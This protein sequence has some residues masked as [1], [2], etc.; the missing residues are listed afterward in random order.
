MEDGDLPRVGVGLVGPA[1]GAYTQVKNDGTFELPPA[2]GAG[3]FR[4]SVDGLPEESYVKSVHF[5]GRDVTRAPLDNTAGAGGAL[6]IV[7]STKA[8]SLGGTAPKGTTVRTWP[9]I[10]DLG[11]YDGGVKS[12]PT[13]QEGGFKFTSLAPGEYYV[14]AWKELESGLADSPEFLARF[15]GDASLVKLEESGRATVEV[16]VIPPERIAAEIAR[17]P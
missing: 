7:L 3:M 1:D 5:V 17:L 10:P 15:D 12:T 9:K 2:V 6:Q 11:S 13:D 4:W 8:A 16:K 14:A